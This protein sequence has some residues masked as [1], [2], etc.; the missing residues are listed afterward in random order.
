MSGRVFGR[1]T[2]MEI[3]E[4][5]Q[6]DSV[7]VTD[8]RTALFAAVTERL[9]KYVVMIYINGD[10]QKKRDV[11]IEKLEEDGTY[12]MKFSDIHVAPAANVQIPK[13]GFDIENPFLS[14]EGGTR[15]FAKA[16]GNSVNLTV[17]HW[18]NDI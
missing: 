8:A 11:A 5:L 3:M 10:Q 16:S 14:C 2:R 4:R 13:D 18:D 6:T 9:W 12:T 17:I 15:L 7:W 1:L